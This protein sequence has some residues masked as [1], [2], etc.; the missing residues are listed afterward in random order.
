V[1][2]ASVIALRI[3]AKSPAACSAARPTAAINKPPGGIKL[4]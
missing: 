4:F 2:V 1:I 3:A